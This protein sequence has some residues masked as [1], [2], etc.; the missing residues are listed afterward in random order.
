[1]EAFAESENVISVSSM[2][3]FEAET[4]T[5]F[6]IRLLDSVASSMGEVWSNMSVLLNH[7]CSLRNAANELG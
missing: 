7:L 6:D 1:M 2:A 4:M 3:A 5:W